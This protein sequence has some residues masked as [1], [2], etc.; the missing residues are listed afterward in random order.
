MLY[1]NALPTLL[2]HESAIS[3]AWQSNKSVGKDVIDPR[4][5][6]IISCVVVLH[7]WGGKTWNLDR[8]RFSRFSCV[9]CLVGATFE[10]IYGPQIWQ[11]F[12]S[13]SRRYICSGNKPKYS[14]EY[15]Q[16]LLLLIHVDCSANTCFYKD[17]LCIKLI[18]I[19]P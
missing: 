1:F 15:C 16:T 4:S 17:Y 11:F 8:Q 7:A 12:E 5:F 18:D 10:T 13:L 2:W 19:V 14:C 3:A 6:S 9:R